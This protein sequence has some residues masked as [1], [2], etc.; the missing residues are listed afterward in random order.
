MAEPAPYGTVEC[1]CDNLAQMAAGVVA[2]ATV[3][4]HYAEL[5][6]YPGLDFATRCTTAYLRAMV[7]AHEEV[8]R[9]R[10]V[11]M[12]R[13]RN[14]TSGR[15]RGCDAGTDPRSGKRPLSARSLQRDPPQQGAAI[16]VR[17]LLP[18]FGLAVAWGPPKC[19]KSFLIFDLLMHVALGWA[20]Q[21]RRVEQGVV[22]YAALEGAQGFE[23]RAVAFQ[24]A[25]LDSHD[26]EVPF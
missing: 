16:P 9:S 21:G 2:H 17:G 15:G 22:V 23:A 24:N 10:A 14:R 12:L 1:A 3:M 13:K 4:Q 6:F 5:R 8:E 7:A 19:G 20:Y 18:M 11:T 26:G 25:H